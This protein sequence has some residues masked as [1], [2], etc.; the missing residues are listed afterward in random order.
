M[1]ANLGKWKEIRKFVVLRV[2]L[3]EQR[4]T[5]TN[6]ITEI[7]R[8]GRGRGMLEGGKKRG[9]VT[10]KGEGMLEEGR[11]RG[12]VVRKIWTIT[13]STGYNLFLVTKQHFKLIPLNEKFLNE[14]TILIKSV[15]WEYI[16]VEKYSINKGKYL[17]LAVLPQ[18][19]LDP[20]IFNLLKCLKMVLW[21]YS[22]HS[23]YF[24]FCDNKRVSK[25]LVELVQHSITINNNQNCH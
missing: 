18:N 13:K 22:I 7:Q 6:G 11:R 3:C 25:I 20:T 14:Q 21:S 24:I 5:D 17:L 1:F 15:L 2:G 19:C 23:L 16:C 8:G 9:R 12:K 4:D 10:G